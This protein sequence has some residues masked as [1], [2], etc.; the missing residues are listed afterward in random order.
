VIVDIVAPF[1]IA[2]LVSLALT[3]VVRRLAFTFGITDMP[4]ARRVHTRPTPRAGGIAVTIATAAGLAFCQCASA[5]L[6][7]FVVGGALFLFAVG[8]VDDLRSLPAGTKLVAQL[9]A[10]ILAVAGGVRLPLFAAVGVPALEALDVALT[11]VWIVLITNALNLTD[12]LDG[13]ASGIGVIGLLWL[14]TIAARSGDLV[15]ALPSLI[16]AGALLGFLPYNF[17]PATIFLGDSGSLVI[18]YA[19][20]V[21]PLT[22]R[23]VPLVTPLAALLLVAVPATDTGLAIARRFLSR[24]LRAWAEGKFLEGV[25]DGL[26][27]T[28]RPDRRHIH[29]RL[30]DLGFTQRRAVNLLWVA[31]LSTAA[32]GYLVVR[33]PGWP[34]DVVALGLAITVIWLVQT[35]GFDELQPARSGLILPVVRRLARHRALIL[36]LDAGLVVTAYAGSLAIAGGPRM[37][38]VPVAA[39]IAVMALAQI[40]TFAVLGVYRTAWFMTEASGFGMLVRAC[41][42]GTTAGYIALR[43]LVL[44]AG[45]DAAVVHFLLLLPAVTLTRF[46]HALLTHARRSAGPERAL[47]CGTSAEAQHALA[48]LRGNGHAKTFEPIGFV[49]LRPRLQGRQVGH[50]PVFGTLEGL[51]GILDERRVSHLIVADPML[52]GAAFRWVHAVCRHH[53]VRLHRY[54]ETLETC[55]APVARDDQVVVAAHADNGHAPAATHANGNGHA[56]NGHANGNRNGHAA[57][58]NGAHAETHAA[59]AETE[60]AL[61]GVALRTI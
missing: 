56:G 30:I 15:A 16:L 11:V 22:G 38:L 47:I 61:P 12:G 57:N 42:A 41:A 55:D 28:A 44:P 9:V 54:V 52:D 40:G 43:L 36:V 58:G 50:L 2:F 7:P 1:T 4:D 31:A 21:L 19:L 60:A 25:H 33:T 3:P 32:L 59:P 51:P 26:R 29:H 53:G 34:V 24:C 39:A 23:D 37:Q 6:G 46:S 5:Q 17:N 10:A 45:G 48:R 8:I 20:A 14:T 13:L 35:L 27:N 49:E 18:G